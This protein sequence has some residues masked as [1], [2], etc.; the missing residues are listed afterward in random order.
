MCVCV[1]VCGEFTNISVC[2]CVRLF[3]DSRLDLAIKRQMTELGRACK[4]VHTCTA[5]LDYV[6]ECVCVCVLCMCLL[7]P[8][9][10][11]HMLF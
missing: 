10:R 4:L 11:I 3:V 8:I 6:C 9:S 1:C 2:A 7:A 5:V